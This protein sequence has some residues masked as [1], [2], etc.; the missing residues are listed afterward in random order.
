L[1]LVLLDDDVRPGCYVH[2]AGFQVQ[3]QEEFE[4]SEFGE[5]FA[6]LAAR[7]KLP[8]MLA[9]YSQHFTAMS[10]ADET[11]SESRL[12][13]CETMYSLFY[14]HFRRKG[15]VLSSPAGKLQVS[16]FDSQAGFEAYL[17][18]KMASEVTGIYDPRSNRFLMYDY[19]QNDSFVTRTQ[20]ALRNAQKIHLQMDRLRYLDGV[21]RRARDYR[22]E[23]NIG[24]IMHEVAH[25]LS[26]NSGMLNRQGDVPSWLAEGLACYCESTANGSWQGIGEVN[27]G[28][29]RGLAD[30]ARNRQPLL[31]LREMLT[32]DGWLRGSDT[33]TILLGYAQS[34]ALFRFLVEEQP[35]RLRAYL[36]LIYPERISERRLADFQQ[37]F[38]SDLAAI[39]RQYQEYIKNLIAQ[40]APSHW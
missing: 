25:Q 36:K 14:D 7:H 8:P 1:R 16:M 39:E 35:H 27:P 6:G 3:T 4:A 18:R 2:C 30:A 40:H 19:G 17:G 23:T 34:W 21:Q 10:N 24:T 9:Y 31:T 32:Q 15:L 12:K 26:F 13:L 20:E 33:K 28:R 37:A 22:A 5:K 29:L 11:F 38:G